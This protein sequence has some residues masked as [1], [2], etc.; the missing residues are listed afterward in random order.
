ML[1]RKSLSKLLLKMVF[2]ATKKFLFHVKT[3]EKITDVSRYGIVCYDFF[4]QLHL[5]CVPMVLQKGNASHPILL[6][7][8]N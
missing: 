6:Y 8:T 3:R 2:I 5:L 4:F 1:F 7:E